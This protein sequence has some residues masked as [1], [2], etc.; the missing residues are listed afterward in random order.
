MKQDS[1]LR[2]ELQLSVDK[3]VYV[4]DSMIMLYYINDDTKRISVFARNRLAEIHA[5][6]S[7]PQWLHSRSELNPADKV[8]RGVFA[9]QLVNDS[10]WT[11]RPEFMWRQHILCENSNTASLDNIELE[12]V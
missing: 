5:R 10:C 11:R 2:K 8:S 9:S 1:V 6:S 12:E 4:T 3:S 7:P